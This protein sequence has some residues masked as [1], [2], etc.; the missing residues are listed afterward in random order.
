MKHCFL[1]IFYYVK[2]K[3]KRLSKSCIWHEQNA[4]ASAASGQAQVHEALRSGKEEEVQAE[5][6]IASS[7]PCPG[8]L[9]DKGHAV[10]GKVILFGQAKTLIRAQKA[11][12]LRLSPRAALWRLFTLEQEARRPSSARLSSLSS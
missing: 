12:G 4:T 11:K 2:K 6:E 1:Y 3:K 8:S 9:Q 10:R 7:S 5:Q